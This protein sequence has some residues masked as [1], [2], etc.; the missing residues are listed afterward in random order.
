MYRHLLPFPVIVVLVTAF[1]P[2]ACEECGTYYDSQARRR[3]KSCEWSYCGFY[4]CVV[5]TRISADGSSPFDVCDDAYNI[6]ARVEPR[7]IAE[8]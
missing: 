1:S 2:R 8:A 6:R 3:C 7:T 5:K 4:A